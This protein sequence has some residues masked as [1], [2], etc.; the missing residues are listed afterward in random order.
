MKIVNKVKD[1]LTKSTTK[2]LKTAVVTGG[3]GFIANK[4]ISYLIQ[5]IM[6]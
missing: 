4:I 6:I 5:K 3:A 2:K 1:F